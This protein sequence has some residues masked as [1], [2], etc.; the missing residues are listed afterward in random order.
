MI[1]QSILQGRLTSNVELNYTGSGMAIASFTL[2]VERNFKNQE[3]KRETDF[4]RCKAFK[5]TA[6]TIANYFSKGQG[7]TISGRIQTG[8]YQ[9]DEGRTVY[10]TDVIVNEFSFPL[11]NNNQSNNQTNNRQNKQQKK[12]SFDDDPF[13]KNEE[14]EIT[15]SDLPF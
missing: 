4:I 12:Q 1:N 7:V 2:A 10:T 6:E 9:N 13:A 8:R 11:S 15:D 3:G 5:K 14:V